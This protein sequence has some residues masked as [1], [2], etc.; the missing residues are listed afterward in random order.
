MELLEK[1]KYV[2]GLPRGSQ[3]GLELPRG[4]QIGLEHGIK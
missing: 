2:L 1:A 3:I 4:S